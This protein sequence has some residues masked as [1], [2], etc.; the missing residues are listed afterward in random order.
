MSKRRRTLEMEIINWDKG[1]IFNSSPVIEARIDMTPCLLL[2]DTGASVSFIDNKFLKKQPLLKTFIEKGDTT[3]LCNMLGGVS[4]STNI[5]KTKNL[6]FGGKTYE[7]QFQV[8]DLNIDHRN[9]ELIYHGILG[10]DFLLR[11]KVVLNFSDLS[12]AI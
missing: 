11:N 12:F 4:K 6:T 10:F 1:D 2:I 7:H 5:I 8:L 9:K 3:F